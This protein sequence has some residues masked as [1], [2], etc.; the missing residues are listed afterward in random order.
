MLRLTRATVKPVAAASTSGLSSVRTDSTPIDQGPAR[1]V[2][3]PPTS[4]GTSVLPLNPIRRLKNSTGVFDGT[5]VPEVDV[6][7]APPNAKMPGAFEE[8][9]PLLR[10]EQVEAREVDL[11]VVVF[12]LREVGA[13]REVGGEALGEGVLDVDAGVPVGIVPE[14]RVD[15]AIRRDRAQRVRLDVDVERRRRQ[16]ETDER[17]RL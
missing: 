11:Q 1:P 13:I 5:P 15:G 17:R 7:C 8:E 14:R 16:L 4:I 2:S 9:L 6:V 3:R 10:E 12:D